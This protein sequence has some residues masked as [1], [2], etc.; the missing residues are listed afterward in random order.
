[1]LK[2][3]KRLESW[4]AISLWIQASGWLVW[5]DLIGFRNASQIS[6]I[7]FFFNSFKGYF[8]SALSALVFPEM[9]VWPL[10]WHLIFYGVFLFF[11]TAFVFIPSTQIFFYS[12]FREEHCCCCQTCKAHRHPAS[13][14]IFHGKDQRNF[15]QLLK[16]VYRL[17]TNELSADHKNKRGICLYESSAHVA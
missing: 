9:T 3:L 12:L 1:M 7:F 8:F 16:T 13:L 15:C 14:E 5:T 11:C 10:L 17:I 2:Q 6:L 4:L